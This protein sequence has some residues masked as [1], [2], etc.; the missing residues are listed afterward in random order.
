MVFQE[1]SQSCLCQAVLF[2]Y[3]VVTSCETGPLSLSLLCQS[4]EDD[5]RI[6]VTSPTGCLE[7]ETPKSVP[8][9]FTGEISHQVTQ[10]GEASSPATSGCIQTQKG[11]EGNGYLYCRHLRKGMCRKWTMGW[12]LTQQVSSHCIGY[13]RDHSIREDYNIRINTKVKI[14]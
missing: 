5:P 9:S 12:P 7:A 13:Y 2:R 11:S 3:L 4:Y 6:F 10:A 1:D 14:Q 8:S